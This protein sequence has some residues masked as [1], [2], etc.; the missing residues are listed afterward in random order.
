MAV[1]IHNPA[2]LAMNVAQIAVP[3][4]L[5][6]VQKLDAQSGLMVDATANV[7]CNMQVRDAV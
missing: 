3:S 1:A 5:I 4:S 6:H 7:L 2:N